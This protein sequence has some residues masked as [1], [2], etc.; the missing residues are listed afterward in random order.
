MFAGSPNLEVLSD[1]VYAGELSGISAKETPKWA[2]KDRYY[3]PKKLAQIK[4]WTLKLNTLSKDCLNKNIRA[5]SG[6]PSWLQILFLKIFNDNSEKQSTLKKYFPK[7]ELIVHGG[8]SFEPYYD[9]FQSITNHTNIDFREI[10]AASEGFFAISD[11]NYG[12]G[13]KLIVDNQIFYEFIRL[14]QFYQKNP[15]R[16]WL[17]NVENDVDYVL[18]VST[19]AGLWSYIVGDIIKFKDHKNLRILFSGRLSQT[20]SMFGEKVL[21]EE[22]ELSIAKALKSLGLTLKDFTVFSSFKKNDNSKGFH[23]YLIEIKEINEGI[24]QELSEL[25][26]KNLMNTNSGY[27]TRRKNNINMIQPNVIIGKDGLFEEW[28]KF[29]NKSGGQNKVPRVINKKLFDELME[30]NNS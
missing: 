24:E 12:D 22:V 23:T 5:I 26:D 2:G 20:L 27:N 28:M 15:K 10:Y 18:L 29:K 9:Y 11:R 16:L 7:L 19:S 13:M 14:D 8:M 17:N 25:I 6:L 30:I 21:N 3:P 1:K 4:D